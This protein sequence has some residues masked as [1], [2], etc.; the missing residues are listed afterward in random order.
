[1]RGM[2]AMVV[3]LFVIPG[4]ASAGG[5]GDISMCPGFSSG[6]IVSRSTSRRSNRRCRR[7][8]KHW[9]TPVALATQAIGNLSAAQ[10]TLRRG[11]EED[12]AAEAAP[13]PT[14]VTVPVET[15]AN[16]PWVPLAAGV[17]T[18]LALAALL[19]GPRPRRRGELGTTTA[20]VVAME[21]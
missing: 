21:K 18:G 13:A 14:I 3:L 16:Q 2:L 12:T 4:V 10:A 17:A 7:R 1:M 5:G 15:Q 11:L 20:P 8:M 19:A 9:R 6:G